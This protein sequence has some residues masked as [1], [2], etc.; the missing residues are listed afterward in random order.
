MALK[1]TDASEMS[2]GDETDLLLR[3]AW[4]ALGGDPALL[5]LVQ[6][7]GDG[8]GLLPSNTAALPAMTA[9]MTAS[10]LA[11]SLLDAARG[12]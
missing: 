7:T 4:T 9:A 8:T 11:A 1:L 12:T 6:F 5:D 2:P 10:T 3:Q